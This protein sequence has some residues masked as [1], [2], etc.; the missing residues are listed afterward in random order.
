M[1]PATEVT[2]T[3]SVTEF[4]LA[5]FQAVAFVGTMIWVKVVLYRRRMREDEAHRIQR[6]RELDKAVMRL[7]FRHA[8]LTP[9]HPR[10][11][12]AAAS[13]TL[14]NRECKL[15]KRLS[16]ASAGTGGLLLNSR[17]ALL[18]ASVERPFATPNL[19]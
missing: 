11:A 6:K 13:R 5:L 7:H 12:S 14:R 16:R 17:G 18:N 15:R 19:H 3:F 2:R 10:P 9:S 4:L 8:A 1:F